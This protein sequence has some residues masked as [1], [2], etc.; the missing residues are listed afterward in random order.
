LA[1]VF[2]KNIGVTTSICWQMKQQLT[3]EFK[4]RFFRAVNTMQGCGGIQTFQ[5]SMLPPS[6][7]WSDEDG[8]SID[9]WNVGILPQHC[10]ASQCRSPG[11]NHHRR[12]SLKAR[13]SDYITLYHSIKKRPVLWLFS[14]TFLL[15]RSQKKQ[16]F[17]L[18][19]WAWRCHIALCRRVHPKVSGVAAWSK[20]CKWY[21]SLALGAVV[22]LFCKPA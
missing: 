1:T 4:S 11:L 13:F 5:K 22:S 21:S 6:S 8:G 19:K 14:K 12:E 9:L 16:I 3:A 17:F 10:T 20:N 7:G 15:M 2:W 18:R